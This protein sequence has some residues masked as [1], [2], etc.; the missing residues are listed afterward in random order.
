MTPRRVSR[1][2]TA[3][4]KWSVAHDPSGV[5]VRLRNRWGPEAADLGADEREQRHSVPLGGAAFL[6]VR[7]RRVCTECTKYAT[8]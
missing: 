3:L 7:M 4:G 1:R 2:V 6:A 8:C 5:E